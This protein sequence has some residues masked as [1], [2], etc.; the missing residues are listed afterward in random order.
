MR[1]MMLLLVVGILSCD[2]KASGVV[3]NRKVTPEDLAEIELRLG[4][5]SKYVKQRQLK[6]QYPWLVSR[7]ELNKELLISFVVQVQILAC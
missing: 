7:D 4:L 3:M 2:L 1:R 5:D 6:E